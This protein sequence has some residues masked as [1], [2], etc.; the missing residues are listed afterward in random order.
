M[1]KV[2]SISVMVI[3]LLVSMC[4]PMVQHSSHQ[5]GSKC[6][7]K[8]NDVDRSLKSTVDPLIGW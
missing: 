5:H 3:Y 8:H 4:V 2:I 7:V 1:I 6:L